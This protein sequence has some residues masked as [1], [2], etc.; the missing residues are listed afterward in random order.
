VDDLANR[1]RYHAPDDAAREKHQEARS[2]AYAFAL[3]A[4]EAL[5]ESREKSLFFT[6]LEQAMFWA[7]AAIARMDETGARRR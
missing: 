5:P 4:E 3:W 2:H 6:N 7:N 1:F